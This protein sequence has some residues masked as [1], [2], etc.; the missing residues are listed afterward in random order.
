MAVA[1]VEIRHVKLKHSLVGG[2]RRSS[3]DRLLEEIA[4]SYEDVWR[5]REDLRDRVDYLENELRR[6]RELEGL[7]RE[8]LLSAEKS[9]IELKE[10][11]RTEAELIIREAHTAARSITQE[12][13]VDR[14][15]L[16][17]EAT[18]V[19]ALL[20]AALTS[21]DEAEPVVATAA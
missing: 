17:G 3:V 9:A 19:R 15:K 20:Q 13:L 11:A 1:P 7:L 4:Q 16:L 21:V 18:R 5:E 8:T 2:F 10:Q 12:A 6:H 14:E